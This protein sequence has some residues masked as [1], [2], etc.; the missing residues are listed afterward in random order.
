VEGIKA[1]K[2]P[3]EK[4]DY[5]VPADPSAMEVDA[6]IDPQ[7]R[8][9]GTNAE[10]G[11]SQSKMRSNLRLFPPPMFSRQSLP[12]NYKSVGLRPLSRGISLILHSYKANVA[13]FPVT[14]VN[15][16]TGEEKTRLVNRMKWKGL[17]SATIS[18]VDQTVIALGLFDS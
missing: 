15:E 8:S 17:S 12:L 18:Y 14:V 2:V 1:F 5:L 13:S 6:D 11:P 7:L 9:D 3:V 4:E 16:E 10:A